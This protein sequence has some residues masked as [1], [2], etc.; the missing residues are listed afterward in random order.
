[1]NWDNDTDL[2]ERVA[3]I[4]PL[5]ADLALQA[6]QADGQT[7]EVLLSFLSS[8]EKSRAVRAEIAETKQK[9]RD[10]VAA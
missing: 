7:R 3:E 2:A 8:H 5:S 4:C 6:L 9:L 10:F 1:M